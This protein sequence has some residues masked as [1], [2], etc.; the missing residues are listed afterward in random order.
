LYYFYFFLFK[1]NFLNLG[2]N[3]SKFKELVKVGKNSSG[4]WGTVNDDTLDKLK[5]LLDINKGKD[6]E[7]I[8]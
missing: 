3:L 2:E 4:A 1:G 7:K 8:L 5:K 6:S